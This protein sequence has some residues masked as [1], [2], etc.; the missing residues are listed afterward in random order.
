METKNIFSV[1]ES[2][3]KVMNSTKSAR[4]A[5]NAEYTSLSH[6]LKSIKQ[7]A[8]WNAGFGEA[9]EQVGIWN[10]ADLT[11]A[12]VTSMVAEECKAVVKIKGEE[13]Q[14]LG[15]WVA[16]KVRDKETGEYV[17][18]EDGSIKTEPK[19]RVVKAWTPNKVLTILAQSVAF[20]G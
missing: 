7:K 6:V 11:P 8:L 3:N 14:M 19:F 5:G 16:A 12:T 17:I 13:K 10:S 2:A 18:N 1:I 15:I 9:F 4:T 20:I